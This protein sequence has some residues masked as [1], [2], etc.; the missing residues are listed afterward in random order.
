MVYNCA[1]IWHR[2]KWM[3]DRLSRT[4][5]QSGY[6]SEHQPLRERSRNNKRRHLYGYSH[7]RTERRRYDRS[8]HHALQRN[9]LFH[10]TI[11]A[12]S[13]ID[14]VFRYAIFA[15]RLSSFDHLRG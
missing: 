4:E 10:D 15:P 1:P 2:R 12:E 11:D 5:L 13:F 7:V 9:Q 3:A 14:G 8:A 6:L